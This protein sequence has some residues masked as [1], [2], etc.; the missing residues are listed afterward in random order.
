[1][2]RCIHYFYKSIICIVHYLILI[3]FTCV[4]YELNNYYLKYFYFYSIK[5][6]TL[7][8]AYKYVIYFYPI[9]F[10]LYVRIKIKFFIGL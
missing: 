9:I 3:Y 1:M 5:H 4:S 7:F 8:N 2:Y 6:Y 10:N